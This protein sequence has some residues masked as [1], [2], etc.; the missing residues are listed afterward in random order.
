MLSYEVYCNVTSGLLL[1]LYLVVQD[2][3]I[4]SITRI[5]VLYNCLYLQF[6]MVFSSSS[7]KTIDTL[8]SINSVFMFII[9]IEN[10]YHENNKENS[11]SIFQFIV[12]NF[13]LLL[14][15]KLQLCPNLTLS[16]H[17]LRK[18]ALTTRNSLVA[19]KS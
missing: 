5:D 14:L 1:S 19:P 3:C 17:Y 10:I 13:L 2:K 7:I 12:S 4:V 16:S 6:V 9:D 18:L 8:T 15:L 11:R